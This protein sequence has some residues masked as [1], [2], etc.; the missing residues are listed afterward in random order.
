M[1]SKVKRVWVGCVSLLFAANAAA[2]RD[3]PRL[4]APSDRYAVVIG[5]SKYDDK[6]GIGDLKGADN[7]ARELKAALQKYAGFPEKNI[8]LLTSDQSDN[9]K[10]TRANINR[11]V[12][13]MATNAGNGLMLFAFSG[14]GMSKNGKALLLPSEIILKDAHPYEDLESVTIESV[15]Q[16]LRNAS[17]ALL[18]VDACR[19]G[20]QED[21]F[22]QEF[23]ENL[24]S[25]MLT[26]NV[27]GIFLSTGNE[28]LS[29]ELPDEKMGVFTWV[30][31]QELANAANN[32]TQLSLGA[33]RQHLE[34]RVP[35]LAERYNKK[36]KPYVMIAGYKAES[37]VLAGPPN[38]ASRMTPLSAPPGLAVLMSEDGKQMLVTDLKTGSVSTYART[39]ANPVIT[40]PI[41]DERLVPLWGTTLLIASDSEIYVADEKRGG[42]FV[43]GSDVNQSVR[44]FI[45]F[46]SGKPGEMI[47]APHRQEVYVIDKA[48]QCVVVIDVRTHKLIRQFQTGNTP[49]A[50]AITPDERKLY[51]A[52]EQPAPQ[53]T[54]SVIDLDSKQTKKSISDVNC[55]EAL[56]ITPDGALLYVVT[57]CGLG[58][59]PVF[60]IDTRTDTKV[61]DKTIPGMAVGSSIAIAPSGDKLYVARS[62]FYTRD[63]SGRPLSVPDQ[64]SIID[65]KTNKLEASYP[66]NAYLFA[67]TP[68]GKYLI[69]GDGPRL[70]FM[71]TKTERVV[72]T[73]Q[74]DTIPAGVAVGRNKDKTG[75]VCYVWLPEEN[76]LFFTGL[77]G[78][79][80]VSRN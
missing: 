39:D 17:Q 47:V 24:G 49:K 9:K 42:V 23:V 16:K 20:Q 74:F 2:Q 36:Q 26:N 12:A 67:T 3:N 63:S 50:I 40:A 65:T 1:S 14:H 53:G 59:D 21:R 38:D 69:A 7:D 54:I 80:P 43:F 56:A 75:F 70:N 15:V 19:E 22:T 60:V 32:N 37:L 5:V 66:M 30:V 71:E 48:K 27:S 46:N 51:V 8:T 64:V 45:E 78:I 62:G 77:S 41:R 34:D 18:F 73:I 31:T 25:Q 57:Q 6:Q 10:S 35:G 4:P 11:E 79:L 58:E 29:F 55:P 68:D 72:K 33:L 76:R 61:D 28:G 52:N 13:K 44:D